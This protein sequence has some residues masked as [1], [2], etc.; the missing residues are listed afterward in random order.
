MDFTESHAPVINDVSWRILTIAMLV[1]KLD[2][3]IID[4]LTAL[5]HG[6][7]EEDICVECCEV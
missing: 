7:L 1:W 5:L 2:A 4:V 6:D 3:K